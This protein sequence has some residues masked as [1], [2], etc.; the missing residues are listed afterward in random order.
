[1]KKKWA[2]YIVEALE[3]LGGSASYNEIYEKIAEIRRGNL[4]PQWKASV[5]QIIESHSSDSHNFRGIDLFYSVEGIGSGVWGL[6]NY[7][8]H[9]IGETPKAQD[10]NISNNT[11]ILVYRILRDTKIARWVKSIYEHRCQI[12]S[13][14]I[15]LPDGTGYAEAHHIKPLG[16][17]HLGPDVKSNLLCLCP[18]HHAELDYGVIQINLSKLNIDK[19]HHIDDRYIAYHNRKIY[20]SRS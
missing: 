19:R 14:V 17:P 8:G 10:I 2:D 6:R 13:Y 3:E 11:Q 1:M 5:R 18:T 16:N 4:T 15:T 9:G 20:K 7:V 12:C